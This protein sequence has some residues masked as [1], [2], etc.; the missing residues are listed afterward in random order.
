M[1]CLRHQILDILTDGGRD[2]IVRRSKRLALVSH[3]ARPTH[4]CILRIL[5]F[6]QYKELPA[7]RTL[8]CPGRPTR[9]EMSWA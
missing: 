7:K 3:A 1:S 4:P 9:E 6:G 2:L 8:R 5:V